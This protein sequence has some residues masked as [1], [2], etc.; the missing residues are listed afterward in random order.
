VVDAIL[1][2]IL[3]QCKHSGPWMRYGLWPGTFPEGDAF[4]MKRSLLAD[5]AFLSSKLLPCIE[6]I[7]LNVCSGVYTPLKGLTVRADVDNIF[8]K[9]RAV[10]G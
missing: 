4:I 9:Q 6:N 8:A 1:C 2:N 5:T 3:C 10:M 7:P